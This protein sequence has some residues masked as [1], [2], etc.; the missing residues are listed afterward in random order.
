[1]ARYDNEYDRDREREYD[2]ERDRGY[3]ERGRHEFGGRREGQGGGRG[4][5]RGP[6][7]S[8]AG[9]G[10]QGFSQGSFG[11]YGGQGERLWTQYGGQGYGAEAGYTGRE[12][13]GGMG[14][15]SGSRSR[16][17]YGREE[18]RGW[19]ADRERT[20]D[21]GGSE[22]YRGREGGWGGYSEYDR[23]HGGL[24]RESNYGERNYGDE[25]GREGRGGYGG[26]YGQSEFGSHSGFGERL[27]GERE[28]GRGPGREA[29]FD[30]GR[31]NYGR[32]GSGR[33]WGAEDAS[34]AGYAG[35][36]GFEERGD[37]WRRQGQQ[38]WGQ[39]QGRHSGRG[40]KGWQRSDDRI[41]EDINERLTQHP[42]IDA[43]E[44]DVRV[45]NGEVTLTGTVDERHAKRLAEDIAEGVS[46][47]KDVHNQLRTNRG[48]HH[49]G[50]V[51]SAGHSGATTQGS[52]GSQSGSMSSQQTTTQKTQPDMAGSSKK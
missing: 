25:Y 51:T 30:Y 32:T 28:Q 45:E 9:W 49:G 36:R 26:G 22:G 50:N 29:S 33:G 31:G 47:V 8:H 12:T 17:N 3:E 6:E 13:A 14:S 4:Y 21:A 37:E 18:G 41:R 16:E 52:T 7:G 11:S 23:E 48:E 39:Q 24:G 27:F 42:D 20:R 40:P 43:S 19:Q 38:G 46:G 35:S 44:I 5:Y 34:A 15:Y 10:G 2:R 1:M